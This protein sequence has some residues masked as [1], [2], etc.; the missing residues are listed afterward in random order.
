MG[1][2][3]PLLSSEATPVF[4]APQS[5]AGPP[6][7]WFGPP[8]PSGAVKNGTAHT[9]II[10][11]GRGAPRRAA[12]VA[13][14][15]AGPQTGRGESGREWVGGGSSFPEHAGALMSCCPKPLVAQ[16]HPGVRPLLQSTASTPLIPVPE[17][18]PSAPLPSPCRPLHSSQLWKPGGGTAEP[19]STGMEGGGHQEAGPSC[20]LELGSPLLPPLLSPT[21]GCW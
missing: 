21:P 9:A 12:A 5:T 2:P 11:G 19:C 13:S 4:L 15:A 3:S 17:S 18:P 8:G 7:D 6:L 1:E 16:K 14:E 20:P 10:C